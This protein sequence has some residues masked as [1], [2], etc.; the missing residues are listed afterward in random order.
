MNAKK[1]DRCTK[2]YEPYKGSN[3]TYQSNMLIFAEETGDT[4]VEW[5]QFELC[6]ECMRRACSFMYETI[7]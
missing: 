1:C 6:P 7:K 4:Y 5:R 2:F 3:E